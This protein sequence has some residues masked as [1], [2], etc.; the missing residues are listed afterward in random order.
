MKNISLRVLINLQ[1][2]RVFVVSLESQLG[3]RNHE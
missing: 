3:I 1:Q 2:L